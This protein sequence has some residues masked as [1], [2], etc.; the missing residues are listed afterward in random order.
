MPI[1]T[2]HQKCCAEPGAGCNDAPRC[3]SFKLAQVTRNLCGLKPSTVDGEL[4]MKHR[5]EA[6]RPK[7]VVIMTKH[8]DDLKLAGMTEEV[9]VVLHHIEKVFG[10]LMIEWHEF[11]NCGARHRQNIT[12]KVITLDQ[13]ELQPR[14]E[15]S[16]MLISLER[17]LRMKSA[18]NCIAC[19][20]PC[21]EQ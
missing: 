12:P 1:S 15:P 6:G 13:N 2:L 9:I 11:T 20:A 17:R 3:F 14:C 19:I 18:R 4:C 21:W 16:H 7:L 5:V 10:K 8:V